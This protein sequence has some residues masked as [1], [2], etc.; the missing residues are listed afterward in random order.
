M[1][2]ALAPLTSRGHS[3][4]LSPSAFGE[5][6]RSDDCIGQAALLR[7]RLDRDGYLYLPGFLDR[8]DVMA[9]RASLTERLS[10]Q[11]LLH[12][13]HSSIEAVAN[14]DRKTTFMPDLAQSNPFIQNVVFGDRLLDFYRGFW[15][16]AVRHFDFIWLRAVAPG[17]GTHPHC[18]LVYMG[19]GTHDLLTCWIPYGD[20][21]LD[22]G[23]LMVLEDSH[24]KSD[25]LRAYL[26]T[27][28]DTY[29]ENRPADVKKVKEDG[30]W[31]HPGW[32]STNPV[33]LRQKLGGRWLTTEWKAGDFITFKMNMVHAS[34]DNATDRIRLSSDTRYQKANEPIDERWIGANPPGHSRAGKR[35]RIC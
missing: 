30:G 28:V 33:S 4:D 11:G 1:T 15:G 16:E 23:G 26:N 25:R 7:Q 22:L 2:T 20:V 14:P 3:L 21:P 19:R 17:M 31:A 9:A 29:C 34:L 32:L 18:D 5:L 13:D 35:G 8:D 24:R 12:P 27:D 6:T 10:E